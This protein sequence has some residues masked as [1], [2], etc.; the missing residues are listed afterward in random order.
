M[1]W[2]SRNRYQRGNL[3]EVSL[4]PVGGG[5]IIAERVSNMPAQN[6]MASP[7][8]VKLG[9]FTGMGMLF[10]AIGIILCPSPALVFEAVLKIVTHPSM[11]DFD[12][13]YWAGNLG[14]PF[15]QAG[16]CVF[17]IVWIYHITRTEIKGIHIANIMMV[18]GFA[19]YG[20]NLLNLWFPMIGVFL[21][22][23]C[24]GKKPGEVSALAVASTC[25]GPVFS[26]LAFYTA[27][28]GIGSVG[29]IVAGILCAV[30]AGFSMGF[31]AA[32][33]PQLHG[34]L[35][36]YNAGMAAGWVAILLNSILKAIGLGHE[37]YPYA[38]QSAYISGQNTL[39]GSLLVLIFV[40]LFVMG[41]ILH[42]TRKGLHLLWERARNE[43]HLELY[44]FGGCLVDMGIVG[45]A[46]VLYVLAIGGQINGT[47][48]ACIFA[49]IGFIEAGSTLRSQLSIFTGVA[50]GAFFSGGISGV[51]AGEPFWAAAMEKLS[52][53]G[54]ILSALFTCGVAPI[55]GMYGGLAGL[56]VGIVH[57]MLVPNIAQL[58]GWMSLYNNGFA[59]GLVT[60]MF[61]PIYS[62]C[63]LP[64]KRK[65]VKWERH[66]GRITGTAYISHALALFER[67]RGSRK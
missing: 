53:R 18:A 64:E 4:S 54:M 24:V 21:Y 13:F 39:L 57:S 10:V 55:A 41:L 48:F 45:I 29:A 58:H 15:V 59:L 16:L 33:F 50:I 7:R 19:F 32:Y 14:A 66:R 23:R 3:L 52:S 8:D 17:I 60:T 31:F 63:I 30:F 12:S 27:P 51:L 56:L 61:K 37:P 5:K 42:G 9:V 11:V 22:G 46:A 43:N 6:E 28:L 47:T 40:Y 62:I 2:E 44:G 49:A 34:D 36:L 25:L 35:L 65:D 26:T 1:P 38:E 67:G 20:K